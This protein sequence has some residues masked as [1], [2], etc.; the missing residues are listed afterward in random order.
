MLRI[1]GLAGSPQDGERS[2]HRKDGSGAR[3]EGVDRYG[4]NPP[5]SSVRLRSGAGR[6]TD[7]LRSGRARAP[8]S[9]FFHLQGD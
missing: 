2:E 7:W 8:F 1:G 6:E 9:Q 3:R 4:R 5:P